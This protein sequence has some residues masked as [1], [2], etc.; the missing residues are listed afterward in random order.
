MVRKIR[1]KLVLR[2]RAQGLS[3]NAIARS[4]GMS[5]H[6]VIAVFDAADRLGVG[7]GDVAGKDDDEVYAML[8][9][10]RNEPVDV[11]ERPDWD[12]AHRELGRV[13]VTLRLLHREYRD[14]CRAEGRPAMGYD[15]F[16]KL[17]ARHVARLGVTSRVE[18][19]AGRSIEVDWAGPTM[20]VVDP[21]TGEASTAYLFVG[22]LPYS[23]MPYVE[24]TS[25]MKE[26]TWLRCHVRMFSRF[27]GSTPRLVCDNLRTGVVSHPRDG[28][29]VLNEAY[30]ALAEHYSS[31][32]LPGRVR[33]PRDKPSA[34]NEVWQVTKGVVGA[35]RDRVFGSLDE[36]NAAIREWMDA[37]ADAPFQKRA[38]CRRDVFESEE[39]PALIPLPAIPYEVCEWIGGRRVQSDCHVV[40]MGNRYSAPVAFVGR[41]VDLKVSDRTLEIWADG[42]RV[43]S[44][45]LLPAGTKGGWSTN[46]GDVPPDHLWSPWDRGRC[47][48]WA[49]RIGEHTAA[50][51][52]ALFEGAATDDQ[53]VDSVLAVL[54]LSRRYGNGR[55][56]NACE[57]AMRGSARPGYRLVKTILD[58][59]QDSL[60]G[61][62]AAVRNDDEGGYVR[63]A[64]YYAREGER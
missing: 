1:A 16:C 63:G 35:M 31:A 37:Y 42:A 64:A 7:F 8:F 27:G 48:E 47:M 12:R 4:Q 53:A 10:G 52:A 49:G 11:Y 9:P 17:Y 46:R 43:S 25:D 6:S 50:A 14:S 5:K 40:Y 55:L 45:A 13:G 51:A 57:V 20:R 33:R 62:P 34:E 29:V 18:R 56:E 19:K 28:E 54:R 60:A 2:L 21:V 38:G 44:H 61:S 39:L 26:A 32:V 22:V 23:R 15:R 30:R 24:A 36:V 59:R 3:R 41:R 58:T